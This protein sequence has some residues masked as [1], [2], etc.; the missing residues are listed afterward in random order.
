MKV[1]GLCGKSGTGK[2]YKALELS[3]KLGAE[4]LIDDGLFIYQGNIVAGVSAKAQP[5]KIGAIKT[6]L[7]TDD[8]HAEETRIAI[9]KADLE[10]LLILGTS[11]K[12]CRQI[13]ERLDLPEFS[14]IIQIEE[15]SSRH[16]RQKA[17]KQRTQAGTHVIPAPTFQVKKQFS[18]Y[19]L[20]PKKDFSEN[21]KTA[22]SER[23]IVRPTYSYLGSFKISDKVISDIVMH[24]AEIT[25]GIARV[26]WT[27]SEIDDEG[28]YIRVVCQGVPGYPLRTSA[29]RMQKA[30]YNAVS[31]MT[32]FNVLGI[33]VEIRSYKN[34]RA[35]LD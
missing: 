1:Y 2:S 6:A 5:T 15:I 12:M 4:G 13:A 16:D 33:Q 24:A 25:D 14:K 18:G 30:I 34:I 3:A 26:L 20:N 17:R 31:Y 8:E 19:F 21:E 11:E 10:G 22:P 7:F 27:S 9:K 28:S 32:A 29:Y 35:E 23:T